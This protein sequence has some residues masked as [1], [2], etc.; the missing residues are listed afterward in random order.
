M[1]LYFSDLSLPFPAGMHRAL[2]WQEDRSHKGAARL[3]R[4][5]GRRKGVSKL[6]HW[7][8]MKYW[9]PAVS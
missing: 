8:F 1:R 5:T 3:M 6:R 9:G 4:Q 2:Y 7:A